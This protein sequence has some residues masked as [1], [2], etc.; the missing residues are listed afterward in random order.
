MDI[1]GPTGG[2][3]L[4]A[5]FA[6]ANLAMKTIATRLQDRREPQ[7]DR[8]PPQNDRRPPQNDRRPPQNDRREPQSDRRPPQNDRRSSYAPLQN[9]LP[10][11]K[12]QN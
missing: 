1:D 12:H 3:N 5:A 7:N 8:R 9:V 6:T 10:R 4:H 2:F 11:K